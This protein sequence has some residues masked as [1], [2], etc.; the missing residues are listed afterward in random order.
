[1]S[2]FFYFPKSVYNFIAWLSKTGVEVDMVTLTLNTGQGQ[3]FED[4]KRPG[5][6]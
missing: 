4:T 2:A 5:K 1:M 3:S 6:I